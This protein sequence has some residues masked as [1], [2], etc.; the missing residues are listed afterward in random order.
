MLI[1]NSLMTQR[2]VKNRV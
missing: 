2:K 1:R